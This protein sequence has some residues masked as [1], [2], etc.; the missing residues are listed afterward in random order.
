MDRQLSSAGLLALFNEQ[1]AVRDMARG[2]YKKLADVKEKHFRVGGLDWRVAFNPARARSS[3]AKVDKA[4]IQKRPCFL[5]PANR[6]PQQ[7]GLRWGGYEILVNPFPI[8]P[9]HF[10]IPVTQHVPQQ[11]AGRFEDLLQLAKQFAAFTWLYNGPQA[12]ASAPDHM[13]F[14]AG[15]KGFLPIE[16]GWKALP[17]EL[18]YAGASVTVT[19]AGDMFVIE[20]GRADVA[21]HCFRLLYEALPLPEGEVEPRMNIVVLYDED[22]YTCFIFPREKHRP[23]RYYKEGEEQM[24]VSP[25]VVDVAGVLILVV[26]KDFDLFRASD[27]QEVMEEVILNREKLNA[28]IGNLKEK[29]RDEKC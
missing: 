2:N 16:K 10:T 24:L 26:E 14:Q 25:G 28:V 12:G 1:L 21:D 18:V 11:L 13:H 20:T 19:F 29:Y 4:S 7:Q 23:A 22:K 9:Q 3:A 6:P 27:I 8:L 5:C 17:A 15:T